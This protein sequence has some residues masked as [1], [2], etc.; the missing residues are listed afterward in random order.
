MSN[1]GTN[2]NNVGQEKNKKLTP[3]EYFLQKIIA[4]DKDIESLVVDLQEEKDNWIQ[5][6]M[7]KEV[8]Y[9]HLLDFVKK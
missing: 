1:D 9:A 6:Q 5:G 8:I 3:E 7:I 2:Y 4:I